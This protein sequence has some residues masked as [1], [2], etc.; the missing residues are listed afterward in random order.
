MLG[1][2]AAKAAAVVVPYA[3][4][5]N[6]TSVAAEGGLP[7]GDYDTIGGFLDTALFN[8]VAG[9]NHFIGSIHSGPSGNLPADSSDFFG[10]SIGPNQTLTG[11]SIVFG[12]NLSGA[13]PMFGFPVP[14]WTLEE[15]SATP[16][17]FLQNLGSNGMSSPQSLN[18]PAFS[19]GEGIYGLTIGNGTFGSNANGPI[20]YDIIFNVTDTTATLAETPLPGA[21]PLF[22]SVLGGGIF[23]VRRRRDKKTA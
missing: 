2:T 1:V 23:L 22:A 3:G 6:E 11:A 14:S 12:T 10:I 21:L 20:F 5:F 19:R 15:S 9:T 18:A 7:A 16:T 8:L 4:S 13:N 17:I